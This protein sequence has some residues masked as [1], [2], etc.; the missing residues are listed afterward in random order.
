MRKYVFAFA[1]VVGTA[2]VG[3][4]VDAI[5]PAVFKSLIS[6]LGAPLPLWT[7]GPAFVSGVV[8]MGWLTSSRK[9]AVGLQPE[10]RV[11]NETPLS[12]ARF[13]PNEHEQHILELFG[14]ARGEGLKT[15][16]DNRLDSLAE[17]LDLT[18]LELQHAVQSLSDAGWLE[19][20]FGV[21]AGLKLSLS[22][23][24]AAYCRA[25]GWMRSNADSA[26]KGN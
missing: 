26:G 24:A 12:R 15:Q 16:L 7:L 10:E 4:A 11:R 23:D 22:R 9:G 21:P 2:I 19:S 6:I 18:T 13:Q 1:G 8:L 25:K 20:S 17:A 3:A 5:F 14:F